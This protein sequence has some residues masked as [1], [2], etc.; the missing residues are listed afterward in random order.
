M[1]TLGC[2]SPFEKRKWG[3]LGGMGSAGSKM[4]WLAWPARIMA[5]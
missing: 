3:Q 5:R 4:R 1:V 2:Q